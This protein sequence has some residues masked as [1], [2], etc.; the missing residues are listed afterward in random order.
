ML[1][2]IIPA[3]KEPHLNK[4]IRSLIWNK[5][6]DIE[7]IVVLDGADQE[8]VNHH[9]V[10]VIKIPEQRGMRNAINTGVRMA[11]G[12]LIMKTDA[13]CKFAPGYDLELKPN[14]NEVMIPRR[15]DLNC[16]D[17]KEYGAPSDFHKL[18]IHPKYKKFHGQVVRRKCEGVIETQSFQGS[19][20][21]MHRSWFDTIGPLDEGQF[22]P[23]E[24]EPV[25][26]SFKTWKQGGKLL[27]NTNTW[28]AHPVA[29][30]RTHNTK[31]GIELW[32]R[33]VD[34]YKKD[35]QTYVLNRDFHQVSN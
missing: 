7:I 15:Y 18:V 11:R 33:I 26:I 21:V 31:R 25:E 16:E 24:M 10:H 6:G 23:F 3:Y 17:W 5:R 4:T 30:K 22:G 2:I 13:H 9:R 29:A 1:S 27:I 28:Y 35:Y 12:E 19:C 32:G 14:E 20:W 34:M 8:V